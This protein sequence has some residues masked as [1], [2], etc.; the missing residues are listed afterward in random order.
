MKITIPNKKRQFIIP[1]YLNSIIDAKNMLCGGAI[2]A[3]L[4]G[5]RVSDCDIFCSTTPNKT[6][7]GVELSIDEEQEPTADMLF[8]E[9]Q[10]LQIGFRRSF[11]CKQGKLITVKHRGVKV[12]IIKTYHKSVE[13][14]ISHFDITACM[15]G[16][17]GNYIYVSLD[18]FRDAKRKLIRINRL[19][20][21]AASLGRVM[22]YKENGYVCDQHTKR[23]FVDKSQ[24]QN[25]VIDGKIVYID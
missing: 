24:L 13:D 11:K 12:Q 16:T 21:A 23:Q 19:E 17:D 8:L 3:Y 5:E 1:S 18:S 25:G 20:Y 6:Q 4:N 7:G 22:K 14:I 15:F 2:R 9:K 10:L